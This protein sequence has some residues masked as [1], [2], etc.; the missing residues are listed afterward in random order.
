[1]PDQPVYIEFRDMLPKSM[2]GKV[3]RHEIRD[4][5]RRRLART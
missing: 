2:A 3:L 5:D 1:V 4:E